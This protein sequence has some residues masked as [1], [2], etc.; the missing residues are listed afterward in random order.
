MTPA[1]QGIVAR[2]GRPLSLPLIIRTDL[3]EDQDAV[4]TRLAVTHDAVEDDHLPGKLHNILV[5]F[6][7]S[8]RL[9]EEVRVHAALT[10]LHHL[11]LHRGDATC[12][13][14]HFLADHVQ[15]NGCSLFH[16]VVE[17]V[18]VDR[19][20]KPPL[21]LRHAAEDDDLALRR[22]RVGGE[23]TQLGAAEDE[24]GQDPV[25]LRYQAVRLLLLHHLVRAP[26]L[27]HVEPREEGVD[28][29]K[30]LG[31]EKVE[32]RPE[33]LEVVLERGPGEEETSAAIDPRETLQR[34]EELAG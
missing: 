31:E 2:R 16:R 14:A 28:V 34:G 13:V 20:V 3:G 1:R 9:E 19:T 27:H 23:D 32:E 18:R 12:T 8:R 29:H 21:G 25:Q 17:T 22:K 30:L 15:P 24:G 7:A 26:S 4:A 10:K 11:V 6:P 5:R 33:L